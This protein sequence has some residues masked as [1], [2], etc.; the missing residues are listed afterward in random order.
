MADSVHSLQSP[1]VEGTFMILEENCKKGKAK[2][3]PIVIAAFIALLFF[4][5]FHGE[6]IT[7]IQPGMSI[8]DLKATM[9]PQEGYS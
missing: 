5:C 9:G 8:E 3:S 7:Q 4:G 2:K 6:R 1:D